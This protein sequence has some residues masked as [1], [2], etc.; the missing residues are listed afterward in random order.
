[1]DFRAKTS[2]LR[3]IVVESIVSAAEEWDADLIVLGWP[4]RETLKHLLFG[5]VATAVLRLLNVASRKRAAAQ[6]EV[7]HE[8]S[9]GN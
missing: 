1:V 4:E 2:L 6:K 3:G 5:G 7:N 9:I 8:N